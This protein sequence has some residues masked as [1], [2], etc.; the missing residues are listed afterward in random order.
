MQRFGA[1]F[2]RWV[3]LISI[4]GLLAIIALDIA[5][6]HRVIELTWAGQPREDSPR[7][8]GRLWFLETRQGVLRLIARNERVVIYLPP[9][10]RTAEEILYEE[11]PYVLFGLSLNL[12]SP[13]RWVQNPFI[14]PKSLLD[15]LQFGFAYHAPLPRSTESRGPL[16][17]ASAPLWSLAALFAIIPLC[18]LPSHLRRR[19]RRRAGHCLH[20][21]YD[22]RAT[23]DPAGPRLAVCPECGRAATPSPFCLS[24]PARAV[25]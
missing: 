1:I 25:S 10:P 2:R 7:G 8:L 9:F 12:D 22:L 3:L 21:G 19:R 11:S 20:C 24:P 6:R 17:T 23:P 14:K 16:I 15:R 5:S 4:A 18:Y 13:G